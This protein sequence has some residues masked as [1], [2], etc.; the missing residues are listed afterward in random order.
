MVEGD[1]QCSW[2]RTA[3][4]GCCSHGGTSSD[5]LVRGF[6][7]EWRL[8]ELPSHGR[9][10]TVWCSLR[11]RVA[12]IALT[13]ILGCAGKNS[14][15][16]RDGGATAQSD[17]AV[18]ID[19][20]HRDGDVAADD[21]GASIPFRDAGPAPANHGL[22]R[23][24][25]GCSWSAAGSLTEGRANHTATLLDDGRVLVAGG[26]DGVV[27]RDSAE[28]YDPDTNGWT[29]SARLSAARTYHT[30]TRLGD[31]RVL[32]AGGTDQDGPLAS[33]ELYEPATGH[34]A[35]A[36]SMESARMQ[37]TA[38][39]LSDGRVIVMGGRADDRGT[40]TAS[41]EI[42]DPGSNTWSAG[43]AMAEAR[44]QHTATALS[45]GSVVVVGG[46]RT[47]PRADPAGTIA[48]SVETFVAGGWRAEEPYPIA[49]ALHAA[50]LL[51]DGRVLIVGGASESSVSVASAYAYDV[52]TRRWD[53]AGTMAA[54]RWGHTLEAGADGGAWVIGGVDGETGGVERLQSGG[55]WIGVANL[56]AGRRSHRTTILRD[57]TVLVSG[58]STFIADH[59]TAAERLAP[60]S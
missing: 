23:C 2:L 26:E 33:A 34:W 32:V 18:R 46:Y 59:A 29:R 54:T 45:D 20:G 35:P 36:G 30:A 56:D 38:A 22:V 25:T 31:G 48:A 50:A 42:Y 24:E 55:S 53:A 47:T 40:P 8:R 6:E 41:T 37:H 10:F 27:V 21:G 13:G 1:D 28:I 52:G 49:I 57:G 16:E 5:T 17:A 43:P 19:G 4:A 39:P 3:I 51:R 58:G 11:A 9:V 14:L 44:A 12:T 7:T 15:P 60:S